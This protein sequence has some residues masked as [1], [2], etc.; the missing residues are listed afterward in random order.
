M[1]RAMR[2]LYVLL[3]YLLAP[4]I[5]LWQQGRSLR[6]PLERVRVAERFGH[7]PAPTQPVAVWVHAVS[8]G[9]TLAALPLIRALVAK[10]GAQRVLVTSGTPTGSE[11][12]QSAL[13]AQ[14]LHC[15][16][17]Y[18]LPHVIRRF[19][20]RMR[21]RQV[22]I[23]ETELWPCL[24]RG[25]ARRRVPL[26]I[27]NA[28]ISP[29]SFRGYRR[30]RRFIASVLGDVH[31][32]AA[33]S[34]A[35][36]ERFRAL[37]ASRVDVTGNIKFDIQPDAQQVSAGRA[38]AAGFAAGLPVWIAASTHE[39]EE[40][41]ALEAHQQILRQ[42]PRA[43]LILVPRHPPRFAAVEQHLQRSGLRYAR[44]SQC[45]TGEQACLAQVLLGDSMGE[46]WFYLAMA[47]L[48]FVG[49]SLAP[50]G[51]HNV[52]EPAALGL[53]VLFG[54]HMH[55]F[56]VARDQLLAAQ[57]AQQLADAQALGPAVLRLL[58]DAPA[59]QRMGHGGHAAMAANAGTLK[60]LLALLEQTA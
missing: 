16:A 25:L 22:V 24:Y 1:L 37:G 28:R 18:D 2:L 31:F 23:M 32:I 43:R 27:A 29:D 47:D 36:A 11:R 26:L 44:R 19:L 50:V 45:Q 56:I 39:G 13:G 38:F 21:P 14:V 35:D 48:A 7:V 60:R 53:P 41:A 3:L 49:G 5:W 59:R 51:G 33:Q 9:E 55:N 6:Q 57:G 46:M 20:N 30:V 15:Y 42:I 17:P 4:G 40:T 12:V 10:H 34:A 52:L 54:P 8:V 58:Q